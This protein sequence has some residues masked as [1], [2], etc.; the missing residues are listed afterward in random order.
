MNKEFDDCQ[1]SEDSA[2]QMIEDDGEFLKIGVNESC[3]E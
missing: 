1:F 3:L 2:S